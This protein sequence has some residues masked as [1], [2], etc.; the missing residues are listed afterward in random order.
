MPDL[1]FEL[2]LRRA[3]HCKVLEVFLKSEFDQPYA[4]S[5]HRVIVLYY[6]ISNECEKSFRD[7]YS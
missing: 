5:N 3:Q 6:K 1:P 2:G 7:A 4:S